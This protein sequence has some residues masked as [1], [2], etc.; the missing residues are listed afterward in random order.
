MFWRRRMRKIWRYI[1][2]VPLCLLVLGFGGC[3]SNGNED[4]NTASS[5][6]FEILQTSASHKYHSSDSDPIFGDVHDTNLGYNADYAE[7][8]LLHHFKGASDQDLSGFTTI[9][10]YAYSVYFERSQ[11]DKELGASEVPSAMENM[12]ITYSVPY[13][14]VTDDDK[15]LNIPITTIQQKLE[16]PLSYLLDGGIEPATGLSQIQVNAF[17]T[18]YA[19]DGAGNELQPKTGNL[20]IYYADYENK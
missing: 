7:L 6:W 14:V 10:I 18:L 15:K 8:V 16:P 13:E 12:S 1:C 3:G 4:T 19:K 11:H 17:I 5:V 9:T 2:F 20:A